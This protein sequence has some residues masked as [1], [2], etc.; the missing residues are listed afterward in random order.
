[1]ALRTPQEYRASL[2]D[3][4]VIYYKGERVKAVTTHPVLGVAVQH[5]SI[6]YAMAENP[7]YRDLA[8]VSDPQTGEAISRYF[9]LP[10]SSDDLLKRSQLIETATSLDGPWWCSSKKSVAMR[11]LPYTWWHGVWMR[12]C[13]PITSAGYDS[14]ISI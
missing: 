3:E 6:D 11:C 9:H 5:A 13:T 12:P 2:Q 7:R 10:R 1:M 14:F 4:R 8:M